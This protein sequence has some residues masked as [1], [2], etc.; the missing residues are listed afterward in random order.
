MGNDDAD[1][2]SV[3]P[4]VKKKSLLERYDVPIEN[5]S[6]GY[7]TQCTGVKELERIVHILR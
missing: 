4:F 6:Y 1:L 7:I 3:K 5:L 2:V